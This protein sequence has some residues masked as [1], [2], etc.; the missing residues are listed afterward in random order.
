MQKI[1]LPDVQEIYLSARKIDLPDARLSGRLRCSGVLS[2]AASCW[3]CR[4]QYEMFRTKEM[5]AKNVYL[6]LI[7]VMVSYKK[8]SI[9]EAQARWF[10]GRIGNP[11]FTRPMCKI[12]IYKYV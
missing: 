10:F 5:Y 2:Q 1:D 11:H 8:T 3:G 4:V 6:W 7:D 12:A 9:N